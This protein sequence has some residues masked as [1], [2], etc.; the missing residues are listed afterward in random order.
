MK[1]IYREGVIVANAY[2][3]LGASY[4]SDGKVKV[5]R[6]EEGRGSGIR[7]SGMYVASS[8]HTIWSIQKT[9]SSTVLLR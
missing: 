7:G 6:D 1:A 5:K 4:I 9:G 3:L 2:T 8:K